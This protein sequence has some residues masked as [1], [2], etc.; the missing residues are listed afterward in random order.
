MNR[1]VLKF[2]AAIV[3]LILVLIGLIALMDREDAKRVAANK[4]ANAQF[5]KVHEPYFAM[6]AAQREKMLEKASLLRVGD[7]ADRVLQLLGKATADHTAGSKTI[8]PGPTRRYLMYY[9]T[10]YE[11]GMV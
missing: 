4:A 8:P 6:P 3:P 11:S 7:S 5:V 10:I 1:T 2:I 9:I